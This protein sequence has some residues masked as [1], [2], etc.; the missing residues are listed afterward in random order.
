MHA[1]QLFSKHFC[2]FLYFSESTKNLPPAWPGHAPLHKVRNIKS[3]TQDNLMNVY[4][5]SKEIS[6]DKSSCP[7]EGWAS[8]KCY[9][10]S[11]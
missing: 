11:K 3:I 9:N 5:L 2:I 8:F 7:Y 1:M 6:L 4:S 10:P